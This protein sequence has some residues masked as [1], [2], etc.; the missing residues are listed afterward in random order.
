MGAWGVG[1]FEDDTAMDWLDE[2]LAAAGASA[3]AGALTAVNETPASDY[4][5]YTDGVN[6]RA[7]AETVAIAFG[8]PAENSDAAIR[9]QVNEH[10]E[11][12]IA[13]YMKVID[14]I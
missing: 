10:A 3:V 11:E 5:E 9:G 6:G 14:A 7:A 8:Y 2:E 12:I 1:A 13:I 4:L